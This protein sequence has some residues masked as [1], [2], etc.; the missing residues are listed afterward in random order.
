ELQRSLPRLRATV[1]EKSPFETGNLRQPP[2]KL[3]LVWVKEQIGN[4]NQPPRLRFQCF[5]DRRMPVAEGV[6][7]DPTQKIEIL[8]PARI[9]QIHAAALFQKNLVPIISRHQKGLFGTDYGRQTHALITSVPH[10]NL[11]R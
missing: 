8:F 1:S 5:L 7:A 6:H 4:V 2:G 9:P 11:V 10:S 3:S